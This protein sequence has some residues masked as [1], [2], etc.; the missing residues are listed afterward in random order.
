[1]PAEF[2]FQGLKTSISS[3]YDNQSTGQHAEQKSSKPLQIDSNGCN[4]RKW[5]VIDGWGQNWVLLDT[6]TDWGFVGL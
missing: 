3:Q 6:N 2:A 5:N 4:K 1:M